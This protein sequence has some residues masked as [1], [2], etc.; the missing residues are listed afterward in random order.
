[1]KTGKKLRIIE[2][3]DDRHAAEGCD[4]TPHSSLESMKGNGVYGKEASGGE[5]E[6]RETRNEVQKR[7]LSSQK[8]DNAHVEGQ[9]DMNDN[10][11]SQSDSRA[12][13]VSNSGIED[14]GSEGQ[15]DGCDESWHDGIDGSCQDRRTGCGDKVCAVQGLKNKDGLESSVQEVLPHRPYC[16]DASDW[17]KRHV[18]QEDAACEGSILR[19]KGGGCCLTGD[20]L[21]DAFHGLEET[22]KIH[23]HKNSIASV[24]ST[25]LLHKERG[26]LDKSY[27]TPAYDLTDCDQIMDRSGKMH[28]V[29]DWTS[30]HI[31]D[32]SSPLPSSTSEISVCPLFETEKHSRVA[33]ENGAPSKSPSNR[34]GESLDVATQDGDSYGLEDKQT[35]RIGE[36]L[37]TIN[38]ALLQH[39]LQE[40]SNDNK[41]SNSSNLVELTD[42]PH[43]RIDDIAL[44]KEEIEIDSQPRVPQHVA[45]SALPQE[46]SDKDVEVV[47]ESDEA[48]LLQEPE[49]LPSSQD[50]TA[51]QRELEVWQKMPVPE[52]RVKQP[53]GEEQQQAVACV[54]Q[55]GVSH[56]TICVTPP[57]PPPRPDHSKG[58]SMGYR[59]ILAARSLGR[60]SSNKSSVAGGHATFPSPRSLRKRNPLLASKLTQC[61]VS[62]QYSDDRVGIL[63]LL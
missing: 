41:V 8:E 13:Y 16:D 3:G 55:A 12:P 38:V 14:E 61:F 6:H 2:S 22:S 11:T 47:A 1:L 53:H 17:R 10:D 25:V 57:E 31:P 49:L 54:P 15:G 35:Q 27:S 63:M 40:N 62:S 19:V 4:E 39:H 21:T 5:E 50:L 46:R 60:N 24:E 20:D 36:I 51:A 44:D 32:H 30:C 9:N 7:R 42:L 28:V 23:R 33:S 43:H 59:A 26:R 18:A 34:N 52:I 37:E 48:R 58:V 29:E 56:I 45:R